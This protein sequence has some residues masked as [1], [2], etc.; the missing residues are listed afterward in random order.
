M[1]AKLGKIF[2]QLSVY[3]IRFAVF[4][5]ADSV[6]NK[7]LIELSASPSIVVT[8]LCDRTVL[9]KAKVHIAD[10]QLIQYGIYNLGFTV[11]NG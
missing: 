3:L 10:I 9:I 7:K 1:P 5:V 11:I 8:V 4:I 2:K 6:L